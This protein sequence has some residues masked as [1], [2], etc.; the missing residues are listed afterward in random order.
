MFTKTL[1]I[2]KCTQ[3]QLNKEKQQQLHHGFMFFVFVE[4]SIMLEPP[5]HRFPT[6]TFNRSMEDGALDPDWPR[7]PKP[8][9]SPE[10]IPPLSDSLLPTPPYLTWACPTS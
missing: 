1:N 7:P 4:K 8:N 2:E 5:S 6:P 3:K 10:V 9:A